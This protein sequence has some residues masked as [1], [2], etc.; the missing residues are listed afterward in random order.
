VNASS[1]V[2][3]LLLTMARTLR[4]GFAEHADDE[5]LIRLMTKALGRA[6]QTLLR[7]TDEDAWRLGLE[8]TSEILLAR[9][10][11]PE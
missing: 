4:H 6:A 2:D 1:L 9:H 5:Q 11:P 10:D 7:A 8:Y 3:Q